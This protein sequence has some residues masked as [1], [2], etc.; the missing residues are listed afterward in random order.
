MSPFCYLLTEL[1]THHTGKEKG[2][3][4]GLTLLIHD[5]HLHI[6]GPPFRGKQT[7]AWGGSRVVFLKQEEGWGSQVEERKTTDDG[8]ARK[9]LLIAGGENSEGLLRIS[10]SGSVFCEW[11]QV[12]MIM[13]INGFI[14]KH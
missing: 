11:T 9:T 14:S 13:D 8:E 10:L 1:D 12:I 2:V 7:Y 3:W 5:M 6:N 4:G